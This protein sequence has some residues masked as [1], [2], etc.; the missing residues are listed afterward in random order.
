MRRRIRRM[1][2]VVAFALALAS[3]VTWAYW[4]QAGS[5]NASTLTAATL[6]AAAITV[7]GSAV[8]SLTVAWTAQASLNPTSASNSEITYSVERQLDNGS[9]APVAGGGCSGTKAYNTASCSDAPAAA[10]SYGYRVV[11]SYRSWTATSDPAGPVTVTIDNSAPTANSIVRADATPTNA[12]SAQWTVTFSESVTGVDSGDFEVARTGGLTGGAVS[13]VT[14]SGTTYIVTSSTGSG[15]GT[16]GLNLADDDTIVD[17]FSQKLGGAGIGNGDFSGQTYTID[18][19]PPT[20]SSIV[21]LDA[22][23]S[24]A[25]SVQWTVTFSESVTD[26][27]AGDF[28]LANVGLSSPSITSVTGSGA[29]YTVT[30]ATGTG[31]GTLGLNLVDDDTIIDAATTKL[32]GA[33]TGNGNLTGQIYTLDLTAPTVSSIV[34]VGSSSTTNAS[35]VQWTVTFSEAV[36]GVAAA[37]FALAANGISGAAI[38]LISGAGASYTVTASTGTGEGTLGLNLVDDDTIIDAVTNKLGGTGIGNG[39]LTGQTHLLDVLAPTISSIVR[40]TSTPTNTTSVQWTV[41]FSE[42]V[43]GV[44]IADFVLANSGLTVPSITSVTGSTTTYTV[45]AS[46][47][48]GDGTLGLNL[49]DDDTIT[50]TIANKLGG[51]GTGNGNSTGQVYTI[52]KTP[53]AAP[54]ASPLPS[55]D[56]GLAPNFLTCSVAATTRYVN[57]AIKGAVNVTATFAAT[58][59]A[60]DAFVFSMTTPG[61]T[62]VTATVTSSPPATSVSTTLNLTSLLDGTVTMTVFTRDLAGNLSTTSRSPTIVIIKDTVAPLTANYT[63]GLFPKVTGN[64]ECGAFISAQKTSGGSPDT[65][66]I[67][68]GF[69][70]NI[71]V[72]LLALGGAYDVTSTDL[73]GNVSAVVRAD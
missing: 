32:G 28:A 22:T 14:G 65:D 57:N 62:A 16:L 44:N 69:S 51:T 39:S 19:T 4:T 12:G 60:G 8:N 53:P 11:A 37:D 9:W 67:T 38:S 58:P 26:V 50:D 29:S 10:G 72:G 34:R 36:T 49:V 35:S 30:A 40:A 48:T 54:A 66:R 71:S 18:K 55:I 61:S 15:D 59:N 45:T 3:A 52:D 27:G 25:G 6:D 17:T 47:G 2:G 13:S 7:P 24:N 43:T 63:G 20:V 21:R 46:T 68:S 5:G 42:S 31:V 70:Y 64:A 33:G 23:P 1:A 73:A 56:N 41:T